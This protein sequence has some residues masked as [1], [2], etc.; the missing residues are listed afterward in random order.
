VS[1]ATV[2]STIIMATPCNGC[3]SAAT[4]AGGLDMSTQTT[5]YTNLTTG[6]ST[7]PNCGAKAY[8]VK[9]N[10]AGSLLYQKVVGTTIPTGCGTQMPKN[11][12]PFL[13]TTQTNLIQSWIND[14]ALP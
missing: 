5:A 8:V 9:A 10:A 3:H 13:T 6:T 2:Y 7:E 12:P 14:G 4:K 1:F 11:G